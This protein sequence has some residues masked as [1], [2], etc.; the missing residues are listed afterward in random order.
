MN[1][2]SKILEQAVKSLPLS[3]GV[4]QFFDKNGKIIYIGKAKKLR[5][6]VL[7]Y[8]NK[9]QVGKTKVLV[10]KIVDIEHIVV[11]TESDALLLENNLIK[12]YQPRYN[13]M[14]KDDK[15]Y[16][17]I[18]IKKEN[19]PRVFYTRNVVKDGSEYF[20][21]YTSVM[22]VRT[23]I[24]LIKQLFYI[25]TCNHNL[26]Y[27]NIKNN[28]FKVCLDFHIGN[29]KAPC[30]A[31]QSKSEY[32]KDIEAIRNILKGNLFS[33]NKYLKKIMLEYSKKLDFEKADIVKQKI[34]I[35]NNYQSKST[36][37][38]PKIS[39]VDVFTIIDDEKYAYVNFLKLIN[40][41]II[42]AHTVEVK[43]KLDEDVNQILQYAIFDLQKRFSSD[44]KEIILQ[45]KPNFV[46]LNK[47]IVVPKIGDKLK[48]VE[49][50]K[51]NALYFKK[52]K[53]KR[54][55]NIDPN[56]N[57]NRKL[58]QLKKDLK[59]DSLPRHIEGFDNSNIQGTNPVASC[60]VFKNAKPSKNDYRHFKIKTVEGANDFASM[61]EVVY[62]RYKRLLYEN[63]P[64]PNLIIIDGGKGQ[65]SSAVKSLKKLN[66]F[67]KIAIIGIAKKLEEI[68]FPND[69]YPLYLDKNSESLKVIQQIRNESHRF[70]IT[71][72]RQLRSKN[73]IKTELSDIS[74]I[75][76]KTIEEL[77]TKY[78]SVD[79]IKKID[80]KELSKI[81]GE[82]RAEKII[83][84]FRK[85]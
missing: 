6:R 1:F 35:I 63:K 26:S 5:N 57:I 23:I 71:F 50:S 36:I 30:V 58:E 46:F 25:R 72:H 3:P 24:D 27:E 83:N 42:Q 78:K 59:L 18:C 8:F 47:K 49:L 9:N 62:R 44:S 55:T 76:D 7:S 38:N 12:M 37:V 61:E 41:S 10:S 82:S 79:E 34:N 52:D 14:L 65:L 66:L 45:F 33:V 77:L 40:G 80:K 31:K 21:P 15:T 60:V 67:E 20:G 39:N 70:G 17:W 13:I 56:K 11:K 29:C 22:M 85:K 69:T 73:F 48:L 51:R 68:F 84:Y 53:L 19:F 43:K 74:G 54:R 16:P 64:L 32:D 2:T 28:K 4:Y 81:I 75:G